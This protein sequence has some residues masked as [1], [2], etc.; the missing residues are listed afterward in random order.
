[1]D[2]KEIGL[3]NRPIAEH[4]YYEAKL[5]ALMEMSKGI[6]LGVLLDV[7]AGSGFFSQEMLR[8][9]KMQSAVCV[10]PGYDVES[11]V[12]IVGHEL[13][14]V[15]TISKSDATLV[16]MMDVLEHVPDPVAL[17]KEYISKVPA[18]TNFIV[19]VPAF[20]FLWSEHDVF[21]EHY[22]RFTVK[23]IEAVLREAGLTIKSGHYLYGLLFPAISTVRLLKKTKAM[24]TTPKSDMKP[25][26]DAMNNILSKICKID[27]SLIR[28]NRLC[29]TTAIVHAVS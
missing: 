10:D 2:L 3:L 12:D 11:K 4:W 28:Y 25:M 6:K 24:S 14:F 9:N 5:N 19:T 27:H 1:M 7:G 16:L 20:Q 22:R 26:S 17:V 18:S 21:L 15:K 29:G 13:S 23:D 8:A